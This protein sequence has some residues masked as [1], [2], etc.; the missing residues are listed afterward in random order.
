MT[1]MDV[2][3]PAVAGMF[4][5]ARPEE[6]RRLIT[7]WLHEAKKEGPVPKALIAPHAGYIY[8][9]PIAASAY[10]TLAPARSRIRRVVV[11]GPSHRVA[12]RGLALSG[13]QSFATPLGLV[14]VDSEA[15]AQLRDLPQVHV[16]DQAHALEHSLEVQLPFLQMI[17]ESFALIPLAVGDCE[18]EDV[19]EVY[20]R[21]W[22]GPET[23]VVVSSDLSHY[24]PYKAARR[25][26]EAAARAIEQLRPED[27][28]TEQACGRLPIAG[29]LLA[30]KRHGL[31][32]RT[33]DLR[34][35][36]DTAGPRDEVVGY[37]AFLFTEPA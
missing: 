9:G 33:V 29:L 25:L 12:F 34:S 17:L 35:S 21:L 8:S 30:A 14:P 10:A 1:F 27:L 2:R 28:D 15:A 11:A 37:G 19:A 7:D 3:R 32:A 36:G 20:E 31:K 4:Y 16:L 26:D 6:L 5:P 23:L 24:H 13:A 18:P 22:G